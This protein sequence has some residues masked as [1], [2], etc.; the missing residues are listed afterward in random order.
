MAEAEI[1]GLALRQNEL[2]VSFSGRDIKGIFVTYPASGLQPI[3]RSF[4]PIRSGETQLQIPAPSAGTRIQLSLL[5]TQDRES[6]G[7]TYR[8]P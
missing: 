4:Y 7:Y 8:V 6:V 3:K 5:D 1:L 2:Q